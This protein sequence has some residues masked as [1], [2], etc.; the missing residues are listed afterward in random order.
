MENDNLDLDFDFDSDDPFEEDSAESAPAAVAPPAGE[1]S[2]P[3]APPV[4]AAADEDAVSG[5]EDEFAEDDE[6]AE[7]PAPAKPPREPRP[8]LPR[9]TKFGIIGGVAVVVVAVAVTLLLVLG[10]TPQERRVA[11]HVET[12]L[13]EARAPESFVL[14]GDIVTIEVDDDRLDGRATYVLIARR[15]IGQFGFPQRLTAI[16]WNGVFVGNAEDSPVRT[17]AEEEQMNELHRRRGQ[18]HLEVLNFLIAQAEE[19]ERP[20]EPNPDWRSFH[21]TGGQRIARSLDIAWEEG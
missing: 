4:A 12:L 17:G 3:Q 14:F 9:K 19:E 18:R 20:F 5:D 16:F 2:K 10:L 13:A 7:A 21:T 15:E 8:P 6:P 1:V 11:A